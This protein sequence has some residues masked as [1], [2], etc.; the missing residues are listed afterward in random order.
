MMTTF[1]DYYQDSTLVRAPGMGT[2][3]EKANIRFGFWVSGC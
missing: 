2:G 3:I 1:Q